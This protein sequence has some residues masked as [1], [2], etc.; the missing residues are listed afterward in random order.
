MNVRQGGE[1]GSALPLVLTF[2]SIGFIIVTVYLAHQVRSNV[3]ALRSPAALQAALNARSGIY[4][5]LDNFDSENGFDTLKTISAIDR[6][7]SMDM[8][9]DID[10]SFNG[11][12]LEADT[13]ETV[14]LYTNDSAN[15]A[16][17]TVDTRDIY[18]LIT[19]RSTVLNVTRAVEAR[20]GCSAP[21][22]PDTVLILENNSPVIGRLVGKAHQTAKR[23]DTLGSAKSADERI[24]RFIAGLERQ[25]VYSEDTADFGV[26]LVIQNSGEL[27]AV[28]DTVRSHL[29]LDGVFSNIVWKGKRRIIVY[30]DL[31]ITG[32]F[33]VE[34]MEFIVSGEVRILDNAS[35]ANVYLFSARRIFIGGGAVFHGDAVTSGSIN[36]YGKA[37][38]RDRSLL[39]AVGASGS[40]QKNQKIPERYSILLSE[41]SRFDGT[42]VALGNPGGIKTG[43]DV[44]A[45]GILWAQ[46]IVCHNGKLLGII[47]AEYLLNCSVPG[48]D[49][50]AAPSK[51]TEN[52]FSGA[53]E[54]L[55]S[56]ESYKMPYFMGIPHII[57]WKEF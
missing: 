46:N 48:S 53:I 36:V 15:T 3:H 52:A 39:V 54:P 38:V 45:S 5:A 11:E 24:N 23:P 12:P 49:S 42:A 51:I 1:N 14:F 6:L 50:L 2:A 7:F 16:R 28:P 25:N 31:Q 35:A 8:F 27:D 9:D 10:T 4:R 41:D 30:G 22:K 47:K 32:F 29:L 20:L 57:S 26:P 13:A 19:S 21:A 37:E 18:S 56:I 44:R 33:K 17:V 40:T 55:P 43:P 34:N